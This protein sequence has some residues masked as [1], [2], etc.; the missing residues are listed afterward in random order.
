MKRK[1]LISIFITFSILLFSQTPNWQWAVQA[2][3]SL[4]NQCSAISIDDNGIYISGDFM[5][6]TYFGF[7]D[8]GFGIFEGV[9]FSFALKKLGFTS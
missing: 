3:G 2:D 7:K 6:T 5:E 9:S 8:I 1:L 4:L